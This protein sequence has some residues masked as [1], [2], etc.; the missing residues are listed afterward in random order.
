MTSGGHKSILK[1]CMAAVCRSG[2][3]RPAYQ[4]PVS[5][6]RWR[7]FIV[8]WVSFIL[9]TSSAS[10]EHR[11][12]VHIKRNRKKKN[13]S[14]WSAETIKA[15]EITKEERRE[16]QSY[17]TSILNSDLRMWWTKSLENLPLEKRRNTVVKRDTILYAPVKITVSY[18]VILC[19]L[20]FI[21][22]LCCIFRCRL[23]L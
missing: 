6:G 21:Y 8:N 19:R 17:S 11:T 2:R 15:S 5:Q 18:I 1:G 22:L 10:L 13:F 7:A 9:M 4:Q 12:S 14:S 20:F 16:G 23:E 3:I